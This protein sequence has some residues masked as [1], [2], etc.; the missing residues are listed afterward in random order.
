[1][2]CRIVERTVVNGSKRWVIQQRHF[3]FRWWWV[4][5]WVNKGVYCIDTFQ[6][7]QAAKEKLCYFDGTKVKNKVIL[8]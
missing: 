1:M 8:T 7:L 6:S 3:L 2:K 5:A 4:D